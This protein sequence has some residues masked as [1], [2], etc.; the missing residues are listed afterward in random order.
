MA[1]GGSSVVYGNV[2]GADIAMIR[3][4]PY[5]NKSAAHH[6]MRT[7]RILGVLLVLTGLLWYV[8]GRRHHEGLWRL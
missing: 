6:L 2:L 4:A 3:Y 1:L 8:A 7:V 5:C